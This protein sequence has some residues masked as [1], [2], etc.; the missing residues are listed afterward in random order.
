VSLYGP[1]ALAGLLALAPSAAHAASEGGGRTF[2][3]EIFNLAL[4]LAVLVWVARKPVLAYLADRRER[5]QG[6][7]EASERLL[8]DADERLTEW[9]EKTEQL[10]AAVAEIRQLTRERAERERARILDEAE[11][12]AERI[13]RDAEA[14]VDR[15]LA[16]ARS[17]LG[18]EA[19]D[20]AIELA[21]R[22]LEQN[23]TDADRARL[24]DEF[25]ERIERSDGAAAG[26]A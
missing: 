17:A 16:R 4:L 3:W 19:A 20:L 24:V 6:D 5:I 12:V 9:S 13:R 26:S 25:V 18:Q 15:E 21:E 23:V 14:A 22:M 7:I 10:D 1:L 2:F 8:R 11:R